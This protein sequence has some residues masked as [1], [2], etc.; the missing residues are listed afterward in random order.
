MDNQKEL[1]QDF[2]DDAVKKMVD[3]MRDNYRFLLSIKQQHPEWIPVMA[4]M[5]TEHPD[6]LS[7]AFGSSV[8]KN[9]FGQNFYGDF[10]SHLDFISNFISQA[11]DDGSPG[12]GYY[13]CDDDLREVFCHPDTKQETKLSIAMREK[14]EY[15]KPKYMDT[16]PFICKTTDYEEWIEYA[17]IEKIL[18]VIERYYQEC[19]KNWAFYGKEYSGW[20]VPDREHEN[21]IKLAKEL[22]IVPDD[23]FYKM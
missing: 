13:T 11:L 16:Q 1:G 21:R 2:I 23:F 14:F 19:L 10:P 9:T 5:L 22:G 7:Y 15:L 20:E 17:T 6:V 4:R 3:N 18:E 12:I 8:D